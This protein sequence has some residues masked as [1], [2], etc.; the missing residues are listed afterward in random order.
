MIT[1]SFDNKSESIT[2]PKASKN[3]PKLDALILN[4]SEKIEKEVIKNF[5]VK[6]IAQI[7]T[8]CATLPLYQINY[9]K[10]KI[11]FFKSFLGAPATIGN[12]EEAL[13]KAKIN[14]VIAF[15]GCGV[16][17]KEITHGKI[18]IPTKAYRDEGTSYHYKK[19]SDF[20][21]IKNAS[22]VE[23]FMKENKIPYVKGK[24]WTTDAFYRETKNN[25]E[26]RKKQGCISVE[27]EC[28]ALQALCDFKKIQFYQFF[29][30]GDLLDAP[31]WSLRETKNGHSGDMHFE[32]ALRLA[33]WL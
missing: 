20:I 23:K 5:K 27:M 10:K 22:V 19:A 2:K 12:L 29:T 24:T 11:G 7:H 15:G 26:K 21:T 1:S 30:S 9:K 8:I 25:F 14:K 13:V 33:M 17:D 31:K 3:A 32:I 16:L 28:S 18:I 4:Y 6:E